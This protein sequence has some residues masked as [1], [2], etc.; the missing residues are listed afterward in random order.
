MQNGVIIFVSF[1][2]EFVESDTKKIKKL[3][4]AL[5]FV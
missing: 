3:K 4:K 2:L 1:Q 5:T